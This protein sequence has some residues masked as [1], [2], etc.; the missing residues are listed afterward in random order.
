MGATPS[1]RPGVER[2]HPPVLVTGATGN[3]G[4]PAVAALL[5]RGV[6]VRAGVRDPRRTR[7]PDGAIPVALDFLRPETFAPAV[8]GARGLFLLRPPAVARVGPTLNRLVDVARAAGVEHVVFLSVIGAGR[9]PLVP[10]H[11]VERHLRSSGPGFTLLR[12]GFFAQNLGDAYRRDI[13]EDDRLYVPAGDGEVAFVDTRDLGELAAAVLVEPEPHRG[14]A[15]DLT[16]P[17][18]ESFFGAAT[19]LT[20][21]LRRRIRYRAATVRGYVGHLRSRGL[22][23]AQIAVQTA[24]HVGLRR[25]Q[26][27]R[28]DPTL[29]RLLGRPPR[30][31]EHYVRDHAELWTRD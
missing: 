3:V 8:A 5:D 7:L 30:T 21:V 6:D 29:G 15:Y 31:L 4:R 17:E 12:A 28:V 27:A 25:G 2:A 26:A 13:R 22:P 10:H 23:P 18:A 20:H 24:L 14:R 1:G 16:G 11:R 9:N 19:I